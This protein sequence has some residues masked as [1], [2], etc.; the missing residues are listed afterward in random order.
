M[1]RP[2]MPK[3]LSMGQ[4][5]QIENNGHP[6]YKPHMQTSTNT[7]THTFTS[8]FSAPRQTHPEE[9]WETCES[10]RSIIPSGNIDQ[11]LKSPPEKIHESEF[12]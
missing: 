10:V 6:L 5:T 9:K 7:H 8:F 3:H 4:P 2:N 1:F 11:S 12:L